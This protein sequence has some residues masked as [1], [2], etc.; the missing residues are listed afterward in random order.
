LGASLS[1]VVNMATSQ[2][3]DPAASQLKDTALT[4]VEIEVLHDFA[5]CRLFSPSDL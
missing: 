2:G 1:A 3:R 4:D 5:N